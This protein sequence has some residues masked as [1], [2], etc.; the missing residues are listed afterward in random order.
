[1]KIP[2]YDVKPGSK[3]YS[4]LGERLMSAMGWSRC[5]AR[6]RHGIVRAAAAF[7]RWMARDRTMTT[8]MMAMMATRCAR[9]R[10]V[11]DPL[12]DD[13]RRDR[14]TTTR[15]E[16]KDSGRTDADAWTRWK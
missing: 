11:C 4:G 2:T 15:T 8:T 13:T 16:G 5:V 10:D 9:A 14:S 7:A 12:T 3:A 1:M 6:V